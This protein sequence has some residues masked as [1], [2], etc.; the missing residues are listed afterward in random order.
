VSLPRLL[1]VQ[2]QES[3][4][5]ALFGRWLTEAGIALDV[6]RGDLGAELPTL[7]PTGTARGRYDGL[8]VL[9]GEMDAHA[10]TDHPWLPLVRRRI[11]EAAAAGIPTLGICLGHQLAGV[12][13]GGTVEPNPYGR[14][15]GLRQ[16]DWEPDVIFDPLVGAIAGEDRAVQWNRDVVVD[17]PPSGVVLATG[18]DGAVQAARFAATVWGVQFHPEADADVVRRW[19]CDR[20]PTVVGAEPSGDAVVDEVRRAL[21]ELTRTWRPLADAF[22]ALVRGRAATADYFDNRGH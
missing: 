11:V 13:L 17:L 15:V 16:V 8:L 19:A 10:D 21:P 14:T 18:L 22:A 1:V 9:G 2:H 6:R 12:A 4:P 20:A 5:P 3:C 7:T